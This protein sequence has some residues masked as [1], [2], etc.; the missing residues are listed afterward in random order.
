[1]AMQSVPKLSAITQAISLNREG[2]IADVLFPPVQTECKF[3][4]IDWTSELKDLKSLNDWVT[5]KTDANEVDSGS[6]AL[7]DGSTKDR[8]LMHV[9]DECCVT[10]CGDNTVTGRLHAAKTRSL[11]NRLL[12]GREERAIKMALDKSK[13]TDN[14]TDTPATEGAVVDG[15]LFSLTAANFADPNF[16]LLRWFQGIAEGAVF[17]RKNVMITD[18]ATLN[19]M[20]SHPSFIGAGYAPQ[21]T[22]SRESLASLLGLTKIVVA[23]GVYNDGLGEQVSLKKLWPKGTILF[24]SSYEYATSTDDTFSFGISAHTQPIQQFTWVDEKKGKGAGQTM[25]K[26]GHDLTEIVLS[27]KAATLVEIVTA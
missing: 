13:Y 24:V 4:Y 6:Y 7:V 20:L 16:N 25:Q 17:G 10:V 2:L 3:S 27:Y 14:D 5:C 11:A 1:M 26:A 22:T 21:A 9:L 15:G 23:E 19:G 18:L 12:I 8:A